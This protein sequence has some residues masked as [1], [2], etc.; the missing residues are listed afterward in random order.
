MSMEVRRRE[1][2]EDLSQFSHLVSSL[3][4]LHVFETGGCV[5]FSHHRVAHC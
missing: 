1:E 5:P 4:L 2:E 3:A